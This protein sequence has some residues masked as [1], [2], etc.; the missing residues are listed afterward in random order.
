[1]WL[2]AYFCVNCKKEM[3]DRVKMYSSGLCP[4]CGHDSRS[5]ICNAHLRAYK[6]VRINPVWKPWKKQYKRVY[7]DDAKLNV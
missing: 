7:R 6:N 4:M 3:S 2:P 1:M 5:T